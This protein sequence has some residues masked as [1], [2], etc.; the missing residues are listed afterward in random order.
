MP[1][2]ARRCSPFVA[3][4]ALL[5][6]PAWAAAAKPTPVEALKLSPV[7]KDVE[8]DIPAAAEIARCVV[9]VETKGGLT[10][11]VVRT[12]SGQV[13]RRFLD[14]N[15]DNKVDQWCYY[16]DGIEIYRDVDADFNGKA[17]QYRW[18]GTAGTR[19]GLDDNEDGRI[20]T[21]KVIS[22]EEVTEE[23]V[24]ALRDR[25]SARFSRLLLTPAEIKSLGLSG[26]QQEE[27]AAKTAAAARNFADEA[28]RQRLV[29]A[30]S[31][32]IHFGASKPGIVPAGSDGAT[33]DVI[34]YDNVTTVVETDGKHG[35]LVIGTLV[36]AGDAWRLIDLPKNLSGDQASAAVGYFFQASFSNRPDVEHPA[37]AGAVSAEM[38]KLIEDLEKL[39]NRLASAT[40]AQQARLNADRADLLERIIAAASGRDD[41][42]IWIRQYAETVS[43]AVQSGTFPKGIERLESLL[44]DVARQPG[45]AELAPFIK[46]RI[47]LADYNQKLMQADADFEKVNDAYMT[48][49]ERFVKDYAQSPDAAEAMLQL[50]IGSE[51]TGKESDAIRWFT[52]IARDFPSSDLAPKAL[53]AKRRL[54]SVG[55]T[56]PLKAQTLGGQQFDLASARNRVV[57]IHYWATWCEP[58]KQDLDT[59]KQLQAKYG[60]SGFY[61]VGVNLDH[62][63]KDATGYLKTKP[64]S[65]P[66]LYEPG[67][68]DGRLASELGILTLPTMILVGKDG[69]VVNRNIHAAELDAELKTLLR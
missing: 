44:R 24:G 51:F 4:A 10:G 59:I 27:L 17:D 43:A 49:L 42:A 34:V 56:I 39:D 26:K 28:A 2:A 19:W 67:G 63:A 9:D 45:G 13:L 53:G 21:W 57:L 47:L 30:K 66:Q 3:I 12:E 33:K 52:Q 64:L 22:A 23:V 60:S 32:W 16:K 14:T 55:K 11:W 35:Q 68:L 54:E 50:A 38:R 15:G 36:K 62:D 61:P 8:Y 7:Q 25:D 69:K 20:D 5:A 58:C 40:S 41:Q 1:F 65:W 29:T 48:G 6:C 18:L 46:F 31:E 37:V